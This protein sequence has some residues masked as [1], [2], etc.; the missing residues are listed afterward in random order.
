[1]SDSFEKSQK[2]NSFCQSFFSVFFSF[3]LCF[4]EDSPAKEEVKKEEKH[5]TYVP[6]EEEMNQQIPFHVVL[7][8]AVEVFRKSL[9]EL[10]NVFVVLI[11]M[12]SSLFIVVFL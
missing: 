3:F 10:I 1:M 11:S 2:Q 5:K 4:M 9:T 6:S 8:S 12:P 7:E